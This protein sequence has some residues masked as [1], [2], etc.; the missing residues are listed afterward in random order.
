M[1]SLAA[2]R[3]LAAKAAQSV[4]LTKDVIARCLT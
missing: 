1:V 4:G 2:F 3:C